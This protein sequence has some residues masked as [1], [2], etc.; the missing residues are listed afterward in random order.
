MRLRKTSLF[1]RDILLPVA[2]IA[3]FVCSFALEWE[4]QYARK[5]ISSIIGPKQDG[6]SAPVGQSLK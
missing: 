5:L 2:T 6:C 4:L 1:T 3:I